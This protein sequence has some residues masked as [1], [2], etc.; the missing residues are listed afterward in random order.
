MQFEGKESQSCK[1]RKEHKKY[2]SQFLSNLF[3]ILET[4]QYQEF[5]S[6]NED[7]R[8]FI[9]YDPQQLAKIVLP[10]FFK[11]SN[12]SSFT[13]QLHMYNINSVHLNTYGSGVRSFNHPLLV[14]GRRDL[15]QLIE[16]KIAKNGKINNNKKE[17]QEI[18]ST[19]LEMSKQESDW[20]TSQG[21]Q[22]RELLRQNDGL[23]MRKQFI[24]NRP[25]TNILVAEELKLLN[26]RIAKIENNCVRSQGIRD[27][28]A[29]H[30]E[31]CKI[32]INMSENYQQTLYKSETSFTRF[33]LA[34][35]KFLNF[36]EFDQDFQSS[37][38]PFNKDSYATQFELNFFDD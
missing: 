6:W 22:E 26:D 38:E 20:D 27:E 16:R 10:R 11:H 35:E 34:L 17:A 33:K 21:D 15:V 32:R 24:P 18:L 12:F 28:W 13:R 2:R 37:L 7:G 36:D 30:S 5:I 14:R 1:S 31:N 25:T 8:S 9:I 4:R 29:I 3:T 23:N 19:D